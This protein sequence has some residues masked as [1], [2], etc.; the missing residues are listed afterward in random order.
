VSA[1]EL[2]TGW[3]ERMERLNEDMGLEQQVIIQDFCKGVEGLMLNAFELGYAFGE[4]HLRCCKLLWTI[5][6]GYARLLKYVSCPDALDILSNWIPENKS[7]SLSLPDSRGLINGVFR[8]WS[9]IL[10]NAAQG[11]DNENETDEETINLFEW[12]I[13]RDPEKRL[14]SCL[15]K[16]EASENHASYLY[17]NCSKKRSSS[18]DG[19][20]SDDC[21]V[22]L[23][24]K[25]SRYLSSKKVWRF[26]VLRS[27]NLSICF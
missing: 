16:I 22:L 6:K 15:L 11:I 4:E 2:I 24:V 25:R 26:Q 14:Y 1:A 8:L 23:G 27:K 3:L 21:G 19:T 9:L 17:D 10:F 5:S 18:S 13:K 7:P 20:D 12:S